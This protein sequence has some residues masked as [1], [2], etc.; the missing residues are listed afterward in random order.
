MEEKMQNRSY[1]TKSV[2]EAGLISTLIVVIMLAN[3]YIPIFSIVGVLI[4][5]IPVTVLYIRHNY[6][7]TLAAIVVSSTIISMIYSPLGAAQALIILATVGIPLGYCV[8]H[9]K[10]NSVT[11]FALTIM[12]AIGIAVT[13]FILAYLVRKQGITDFLN[14]NVV[15]VMKDYI[16]M[17]RQIYTSKGI[18]KEETAALDMM[19]QIT[20]VDYI[21]KNILMLL[22]MS[23]F[24]SA[25]LNYYVTR[26]IL[27]KLKY[28]IQEIKPLSSFYVNGKIASLIAIF[29][30]IGVLLTKNKIS[31]GESITTFGYAILQIM[32]LLNGVGLVSHH[33]RNKF[34]ISK[35]ITNLILI[36]T[37]FSQMYMVFI[38]L[39]L[40]DI[41]FDFRKLDPNRR[42]KVE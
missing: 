36:F 32:L 41:L 26:V 24:M 21:L 17:T 7:V 11:L 25:C 28:E 16:S 19:S 33:L 12:S 15:K 10:S 6:K 8:K 37:V 38:Y 22:C 40:A 18:T 27:K 31:I 2:V 39:G 23:G 29:I 9:K 34:N 35:L 1:S 42:P 20:N 14:D 4:L 13:L 5:P 30:L 3:I